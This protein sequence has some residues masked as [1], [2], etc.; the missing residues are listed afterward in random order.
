METISYKI[1]STDGKEVGKFDLDAGIFGSKIKKSMVHDAVVSHLAKI[2]SG[3][4]S[5]LTKAEVSG[6]G[7]KPWKQKG[8]GNARAGSNTSPLWVGGGV[9]HGPKPRDY[10]NRFSK[11]AKFQALCAVLTEKATSEKLKIVDE[12]KVSKG[13]T[14]EFI[15]VIKNLGL[16]GEKVLLIAKSDKEVYSRAARNIPG[17]KIASQE[18]LSVYE[19]LRAKYILGSKSDITD[20]Q[21]RLSRQ[22]SFLPAQK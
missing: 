9:T 5:A 21:A 12:F 17:V 4:H 20:L 14:S 16:Q 15:S 8:T 7:K 18:S 6:G 1:L 13:K 10:T 2:R 3:N 22:G 11:R 19:L